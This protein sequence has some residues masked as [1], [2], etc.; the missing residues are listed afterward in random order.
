MS[1]YDGVITL[2]HQRTHSC[3]PVGNY[4]DTAVTRVSSEHCSNIVVGNNNKR[5]KHK[6]AAFER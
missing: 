2:R 3:R 5:Q 6:N 1:P 4:A